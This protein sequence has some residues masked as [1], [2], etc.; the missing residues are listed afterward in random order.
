[1]HDNSRDKPQASIR[2]E[3][4]LRFLCLNP[5]RSECTHIVSCRPRAGIPDKRF[6]SAVRNDLLFHINRSDA[7]ARSRDIVLTSAADKTGIIRTRIIRNVLYVLMDTRRTRT[8]STRVLRAA[9]EEGS[10]EDRRTEDG[11]R[12]DALCLLWC[13]AE[14]GTKK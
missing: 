14:G 5:T 9:G 8:A 13:W 2:T 6:W 10:G 1:M 12:R 4:G 3:T 11:Y 7:N